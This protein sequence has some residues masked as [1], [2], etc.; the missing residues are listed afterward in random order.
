MDNNASQHTKK[1]EQYCLVEL[2]G[3]SQI[4]G[5]VTE[6]TIG[7]CAFIRVDVPKADNPDETMYTRY[8]G[9]GAIYA[10]NVTTKEEVIRIVGRLHPKPP[11]PR[12]QEQKAL[13][14]YTAADYSESDDDD[15]FDDGDDDGPPY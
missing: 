7:G 14:E 2:F 1:F 12:V 9:N 13:P 4:A 15:D 6:E 11:T 8:L 5:F 3:H 10:M